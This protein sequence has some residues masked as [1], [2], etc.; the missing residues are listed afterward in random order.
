M[1][2]RGNNTGKHQDQHRER[3][4]GRETKRMAGKNNPA[5]DMHEERPV[6]QMKHGITEKSHN[7]KRKGGH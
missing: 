5:K 4:S 7:P 3:S 6:D 2:H 1:M